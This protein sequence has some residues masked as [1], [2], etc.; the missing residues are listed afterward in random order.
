MT[1]AAFMHAALYDPADGFFVGAPVGETEHFVTSPHVS[2][3]FGSL[4][5]VQL[6]DAWE[7]L[8]RPSPFTVIEAGAGDG[9]LAEQIRA[10]SGGTEWA[11]DLRYICLEQSP[12]ARG[13][14]GARDL[15]A[16]A[17]IEEAAPEPITGVVIANELFDNLPFHRVRLDG[18]RLLEVFVGE[19]DGRLV[20][21]LGEATDEARAAIGA[22]LQAGS[23]QPSS[24]AA[25]ATATSL[26][27]ILAR[28][29]FFAIDYGFVAGEVPSPVR[30]YRGQKLVTD[31]LADPGGSD[32]TG[33]VDFDALADTV[34]AAGLT[35]WGPVTQRDALLALGY[36]KMLDTLRER[37][38]EL[39][40]AGRW[41]WSVA[42]WNQRGETAMLIDPKGLGSLKVLAAGTTGSRPPKLVRGS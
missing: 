37:Q 21:V 24:P 6:E 25:R 18:D 11:P 14:I 40:R 35:V 32:V 30:G 7:A 10:A 17:T 2:P 27:R 42:V 22:G 15:V 28:G 34:R 31:L 8:G 26:A 1:F 23:E 19:R 12:V 36:R 29:Y 4:L 20:E 16:A 39:E 9:T 3:V 5:A 33:P 38:A 13:A 41:R